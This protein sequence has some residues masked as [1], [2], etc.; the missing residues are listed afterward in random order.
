MT[1]LMTSLM[2]PQYPSN[3]G[4]ADISEAKGTYTIHMDVPGLT[5]SD[6][7][8]GCLGLDRVNDAKPIPFIPFMCPLLRL[9]LQVS[10]HDGNTATIT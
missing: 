3:L 8:V 5:K 9:C 6:V 1:S 7:Q 10:I 2:F 4:S